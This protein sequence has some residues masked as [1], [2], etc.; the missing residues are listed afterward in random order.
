M[1]KG[2][3]LPVNVLILVA[4]GVIVLIGLV[5]L[6]GVGIGGINPAI[7]ELQSAKACGTLKN[8]HA[9]GQSTSSIVLDDPV[10]AGLPAGSNLFNLCIKY[11]GCSVKEDPIKPGTTIAR[12]A[13]EQETCCKVNVCG[14]PAAA[15]P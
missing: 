5:V 12:T 4:I 7:V 6:L 8:T 14:C 1:A 11:K 9:C 3:E 15:T 2:I 13:E 10:R